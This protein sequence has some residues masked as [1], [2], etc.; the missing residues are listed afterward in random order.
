M[1]IGRKEEI[2]K[3]KEAYES[4]YSEFVAVYGRRRVGKTFLIRET[5]N[6]QLTFSHT[7]L[8][9]KNTRSQ[10]REFYLSLKR[11]GDKDTPS[12]SNWQEAFDCLS[13]FLENSSDKKKVV[14]IDEM[15]WMDAPRSGFLQA[16]E[17]FWNGWATARKDILL[18]IC[19]SASS[20]II[21]KILKNHGGLH[22]RVSTRIHLKPFTLNECEEYAVSRKL[23][24][25]RTQ[26]AEAYMIMGGVP[27]YWSKLDRTKSLAQNID[28][29]FFSTDGEFRHEF[30]ELYASLFQ[31]PEKYLKIIETLATKKAGLTRGELAVKSGLDDNGKLSQ[32]LENLSYCGFIKKYCHL[33]KKVKDAMYQ[34]IDNYTLFYYQFIRNNPS[35]DDN[36]WTKSIGRPQYNTWCGLAFERLCLLHTR[37]IKAALGISGILT[38]VYSWF[39]APSED[40]QGAQIDMLIERADNVLDIC[41]MKYSQ[42]P[43]AIT[44]GYRNT[45]LNKAGRLSD[46]TA[47][48]QA[49]HIVMVTVNGLVRNQY[50]DIINNEITLEDLFR[51]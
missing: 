51:P 16:L 10:L 50:T 46:E 9:K 24:M 45:L 25:S 40:K 36:Y 27:F 12:P 41:E 47:G 21:N 37:Q 26:L 14:F 4:E 31:R 15:P 2:R 49:V 7:G 42:T 30:D 19:G 33:G 43:Y 8:S 39:A 23:G 11:H 29:L 44:S 32:M 3:L 6:Y 18:I 28:S 20:W 22:N 48:K 13:T 35:T 38:H 5:F 17:H 34:L 1:L